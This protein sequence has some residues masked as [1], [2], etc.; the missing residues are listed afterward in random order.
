MDFA[1]RTPQLVDDSTMMQANLLATTSQIR[2]VT[3]MATPKDG[4]NFTLSVIIAK[5]FALKIGFMWQVTAALS[6]RVDA[7]TEG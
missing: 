3:R 2:E 7:A 4:L 5:V 6:R 1:K